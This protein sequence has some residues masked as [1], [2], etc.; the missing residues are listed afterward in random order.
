MSITTLT[1][2]RE[3]DLDNHFQHGEACGLIYVIAD[4]M[5][6]GRLGTA[7]MSADLPYNWQPAVDQR[8]K[9]G[10]EYRAA[11]RAMWEAIARYDNA[12]LA[13]KANPTNGQHKL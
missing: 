11:E 2:R 10:K 3:Y 9:V 12:R 5:H 1:A 13:L 6:G 4:R 7:L 8:T